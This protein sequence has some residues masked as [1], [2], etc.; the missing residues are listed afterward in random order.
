MTTNQQYESFAGVEIKSPTCA[1]IAPCQ[2]SQ[3]AMKKIVSFAPKD[4]PLV[5]RVL[6]V[7]G[8]EGMIEVFFR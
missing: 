2:V 4:T 6:L 7:A 1:L 8:K 3:I 5:D